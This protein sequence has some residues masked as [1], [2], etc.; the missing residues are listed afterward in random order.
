[1]VDRL[2]WIGQCPGRFCGTGTDWYICDL[3]RIRDFHSRIYI[4][5]DCRLLNV[6]VWQNKASTKWE[7]LQTRS[8][9]VGFFAILLGRVAWE[10][11]HFFC[12]SYPSVWPLH[13]VWHLLSCTSAFG[14][15]T[16]TYVMRA[17]E[18]AKM[19]RLIGFLEFS[20]DK[21]IHVD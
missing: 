7:K 4:I 15:M 10:S 18:N 9:M 21:K 14:S 3:G 16:S 17:K 6:A 11:E 13:V 8:H 19:P 20:R 1:M 12:V 5:S 2:Y